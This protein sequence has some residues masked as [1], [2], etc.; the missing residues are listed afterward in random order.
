MGPFA[1]LLGECLARP[2]LCPYLI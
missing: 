2:T 1:H